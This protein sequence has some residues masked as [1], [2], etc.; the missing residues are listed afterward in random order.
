MTTCFELDRSYSHKRSNLSVSA[1]ARTDQ[2]GYPALLSAVTM[3]C[4]VAQ[5]ELVLNWKHAETFACHAATLIRLSREEEGLRTSSRAVTLPDWQ[6]RRVEQYVKDHLHETIRLRDLSRLTRLS[7]SHFSR[8]FKAY[9]GLPPHAYI[10]RQRVDLAKTLLLK[11][12]SSLAE[13]ATA[14]GLS[15]QTGLSALF[16]RVEGISPTTWRRRWW[17]QIVPS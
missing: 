6:F 17:T 12:D 16:R 7:P 2:Q 14:C 9:C 8:A 1:A 11:N 5:K 13:I 4:N 15:D 3:L 10:V